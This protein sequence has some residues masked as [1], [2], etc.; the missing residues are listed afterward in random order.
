MSSQS[1]THANEPQRKTMHEI[2][3][4]LE[5]T[6]IDL[7]DGVIKTMAV[8]RELKEDYFDK[9]STNENHISILYEFSHMRVLVD[10][11]LDYLLEMKRLQKVLEDYIYQD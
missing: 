1:A 4:E 7:E 2:A 11:I 3:M 10:I 8:M 6:V 5:P 9:Y